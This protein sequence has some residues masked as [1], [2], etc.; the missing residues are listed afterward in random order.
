MKKLFYNAIFHTMDGGK[1][2]KSLL[3]EEGRILTLNCDPASYAQDASCRL[4]DLKGR[5]VLPGFHDSHQHFL[6]YAIDKEKID[7]YNARSVEEMAE[8]TRRYIRERNIPK[9]QWIQGGG[10]NEN[11]FDVRKV[12]SRQQLDDMAPDNPVMFTRACCSTAVANTEA[13]KLAGIFENPPKMTDGEIVVDERCVPTGLLNERARFY[14]YDI[15][16]NISKEDVKKL[17]LDY[18]EDLLRTGLTT[19]QT[20]DFKLWDA[21][22]KDILQAY[23]ELDE[24][25]RLKVRFIQQLR[26]VGHKELDEYLAMGIK[27][28]EGSDMFKVGTFK[29]LPDG[30]LGGKTAALL[31]PYE[32]EPK[33]KG[34]LT[35]TREQLYS[36]LEKAHTN[37]LQLA[38]HAIGD[39]TMDLV[40]SCY[41]ELQEKYPKHDPRFRI[42][43]CQITNEDILNRFAAQNVIADIQPLFIKADMEVA[44]QLIGKE[45]LRTS[46]N[47]KTMLEKG[48]HISGSSD[49]PVES[50]DPR[51]AIYCAVTS[52]NLDG[53]PEG[54]WM[55]EQRLTRE[56]ALALYTSCAAYTCFEENTKGMLKEGFLADFIVMPEDIMTVPEEKIRTLNVDEAWVGGEKVYEE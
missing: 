20:D 42:I 47:W 38:M 5:T 48:V 51:L 10:W 22:F 54:G 4:I 14:V 24:E 33:N 6:C 28:Y 36:L 3:V 34:I 35:Y 18:Q 12:P 55:P 13:L 52:Q 16:P 23:R 43:H 29:L 44:E 11:F 39:G 1:T 26:L 8:M 9:G 53:K 2:A 49:A 32:G 45:R 37:G 25:G 27:P 40:L 56:E 41:K 7:F 21:T 46:Y 30:S 19:V 17:I 31:E 15:I 50:F